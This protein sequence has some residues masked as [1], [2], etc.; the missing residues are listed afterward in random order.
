M[1]SGHV[2]HPVIGY[3]GRSLLIMRKSGVDADQLNSAH[4][5][6]QVSTSLDMFSKPKRSVMKDPTFAKVE[7]GGERCNAGS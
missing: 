5:Y 3:Y 7:T 2:C 4:K 1:S 6:T